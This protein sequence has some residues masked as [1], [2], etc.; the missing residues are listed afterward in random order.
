MDEADLQHQSVLLEQAVDAL[1]TD[2]DGF[3]IDGTFGRGGHSGRILGWLSTAGR[4]L[5]IDKDP[6]AVERA[7]V[8]A[9]QDE[10]VLVH[11]GSFADLKLCAESHGVAGKVAG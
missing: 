5:V 11:H 3:Y 7:R 6:E 2:A 4:L 8:L 9:S 1:L 10:R